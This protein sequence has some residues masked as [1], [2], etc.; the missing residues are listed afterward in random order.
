MMRG[1]KFLYVIFL[2]AIIAGP[3]I[4]LHHTNLVDDSENDIGTH[5]HYLIVEAST[6]N[7]HYSRQITSYCLSE[8]PSKWNIQNNIHNQIFSFA[9]LN[10]QNI[11]SHHLYLWWAPIDIIENYQL[12]SNQLSISYVISQGTQLVYNCTLPLFGPLCQYSFDYYESDYSSL[13]EMIHNFHRN[14]P[15]ESTVFT[16]YTHLK[17]IRDPHPSCLDW[18]EICSRKVDCLDGG[19]EEQ[20]CWQL[21]INDCGPNEYRCANGQWIP[22]AFVNDDAV[23]S[24]CL[25][26]SDEMNF[27]ANRPYQCYRAEPTIECEDIRC[28]S[29]VYGKT[30]IVLI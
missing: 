6:E 9:E 18:S 15:Y 7:K 24:D 30:K 17:C 27:I 28:S 21:E 12:Y 25:D 4:N 26:E 8:W 3:Q 11:T 1:I 23:T 16:C 22:S 5:H 13:A 10:K 20:N 14:N 29:Q 2:H 19:L